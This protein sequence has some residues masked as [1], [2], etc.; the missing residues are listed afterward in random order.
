MNTETKLGMQSI[1]MGPSGGSVSSVPQ[2]GRLI[3]NADDW[4]RDRDTTDRMNECSIRGTV[5]AVSAMV[6]MEDSERAAAL[7][8]ERR[9]DAG[10]HLNFTTKFSDRRCPSALAKHQERVARFLLRHRLAQTIF[11]PGLV[12]SFE[13]VVASQ[14]E[15]YRRIYKA[16]PIRVD[17]HHHMHLCANVLRGKLLPA[18]TIARRSFSFQAGDKS[19]INRLYRKGRDRALAHRHRLVDFLFSLPPLEPVE[20]LTKIF[21][22]ARNSVVELETHPI[23]PSEYQFLMDGPFL[24]QLGDLPVASNFGLDGMM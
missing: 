8:L 23:N 19:F 21:A 4:G 13:Y 24:S 1:N 20:R 22:L 17:G 5:S 16:D 10:I 3:V 9:V 11:H 18:G 2:A 15:E 12:S 7:A 14:I 6:F